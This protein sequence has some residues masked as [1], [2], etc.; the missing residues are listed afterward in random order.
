MESWWEELT[1]FDERDKYIQAAAKG[2]IPRVDLLF[3]TVDRPKRKFKC[4]ACGCKK[5]PQ[6]R[7]YDSLCLCNACGVRIARKGFL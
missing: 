6:W 2:E 1:P 3:D 4:D 5:T 7:L